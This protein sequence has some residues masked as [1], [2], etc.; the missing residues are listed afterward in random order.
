MTDEVYRRLARRLDSI[1]NGFPATASGVELRV[2]ARLYTPD[3]ALLAAVMRLTPEGPAAIADRAGVDAQAARTALKRMARNGLIRAS[4]EGREVRFAIWQF[5]VGVYEAQRLRMDH[6]LALLMEEYFQE[7]R[8]GPVASDPSVHRVIPVGQSIESGLSVFPYEHAEQILGEAKSWAVGSCICRLQ[9]R[10]A[11]EGCDAPLEACLW[12][13]P[14]ANAFRGI[15]GGREL[16]RQEALDLLRACGEAGLVHTVRNQQDGIDYI[17]NCCACC[18]GILRGAIEFQR[19]GAIAQ[20]GFLTSVREAD[21]VGCGDCISRCHFGALALRDGVAAVAPERC[22]GCGL[23]ASACAQAALWLE[24]RP[25]TVLPP[26][27]DENAWYAQRA[28]RRG[29]SMG[30]I[31]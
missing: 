14:V 12:F 30:N 19:A 13:A 31:L 6:D 17:C 1:P 24:R 16:D 8:G 28:A 7:T 2:L 29:I 26:P 15:T 25:G 20:S 18:C 5:V 22:V 3:E 10:L 21:C 23:C 11:G 27:K 9:R 4:V